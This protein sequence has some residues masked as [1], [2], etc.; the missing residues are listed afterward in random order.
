MTPTYRGSD[1]TTEISTLHTTITTRRGGVDEEAHEC[2]EISGQ[3]S[4]ATIVTSIVKITMMI[5]EEILEST[6][7][8]S[9]EISDDREDVEAGADTTIKI[10]RCR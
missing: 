9:E 4:E 3:S 1:F 7:V 2:E 6:A 5:T 10:P 8:T